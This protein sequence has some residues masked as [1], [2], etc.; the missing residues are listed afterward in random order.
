M[1][2]SDVTGASAA[3]FIHPDDWGIVLLA[4]DHPT[5]GVATVEE[6]RFR[7]ADGDFVWMAGRSRQLW[8]DAEESLLGWVVALR[9][10]EDLVVARRAVVADRAQ[11]RATLDSLLDPHVLLVAVRDTTGRIVDFTYASANDAAC[12]YMRMP[13]EHLEGARL[14]DLLPG[15]AGSGMLAMYADAVESGEPLSLDDY[16]YP[17]ELIGNERRYDIRAV[18]VGDALSFTWRDVTERF[19]SARALAEQEREYRL[20]AENAGDVVVRTRGGM[21][22]WISPSVEEVLGYVPIALLGSDLTALI[23]PED[24]AKIDAARL[25]IQPGQ[26]SRLRYR[27]RTRAGTHRW[28]QA[29][30][31][32]WIDDDGRQDGTV[33]TIRDI[34][35]EMSALHALE[36]SEERYRLLADSSSDVVMH[37]RDG[38]ILWVS[39]ALTEMLG[40]A[41]AEWMG[42]LFDDLLH[43]DDLARLIRA[44]ANIHAGATVVDR[45]RA[46]SRDGNY[47]WIE[48]HARPYL[49]VITAPMMARRCRF[50]PSTLK[51]APNGNSSAAP[52]TTNSPG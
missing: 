2:S 48:T 14:L 34:D 28:V 17:H 20:L 16:A 42:T 26:T 13:R 5:G 27:L 33:A 22:L 47:H 43:P 35:E 45:F 18:R 52:S 38:L 37:V 29:N 8:D 32:I 44:R 9:D 23:H 25:M 10:V 3:A 12:T 6:F 50:A 24:V 11:L 15:Q 4:R 31:R 21:A 19:T 46:R 51:Y 40:W 41:P 7:R 1:G 49:D 39:P 36:E 30:T